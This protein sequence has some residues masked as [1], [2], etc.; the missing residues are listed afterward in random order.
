MRDLVL[1]FLFHQSLLPIELGQH[2]LS[3]IFLDYNLF[4]KWSFPMNEP[5]YDQKTIFPN[6]DNFKRTL[7]S[8][9]ELKLQIQ[10]LKGNLHNDGITLK[11]LIIGA[12]YLKPVFVIFL[13]A[14]WFAWH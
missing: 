2:T 4:Q 8:E 3:G 10:R 7:P 9:E 14:T 6:Q 5:A 1:N 13:L 11:G 12:A